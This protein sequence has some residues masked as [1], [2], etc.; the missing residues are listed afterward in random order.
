MPVELRIC[1]IGFGS[2][3]RTHLAALSALPV[4][5]PLPFRPVVDTVVTR[6]ARE[7][8][9]GLALAG[10]GHIAPAFGDGLAGRHLDAAVVASSNDRHLADSRA[11]LGAGLPLYVEK[12]IGRTPEEAAELSRLAAASNRPVQ[13]GLVMRY[14]PAVARSRALLAAG[15]AGAVRQARLTIF[16]GSYLDPSRPL[17]WRMSRERAGGGAM[18][19]L[20]LHLLDLARHLL[21]EMRLVAGRHHTFVAE[22][23]GG[24]ADADDWAWAELTTFAGAS[25]TVEASR[26]AYGGEGSRLEVFGTEGSLRCDLDEAAPPRLRR[27][28]GREREWLERAEGEPGVAAV[29][30]L[31]PPARQSLGLFTDLHAAALHHFLMRVAG[32]DPL[33]GLAP[34]ADDSAVAENLAAQALNVE[35]L[36]LVHA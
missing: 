14:H 12:P 16:H 6:R 26:I 9:P 1:V 20:G 36:E 29:D 7:L 32:R 17:S 3:A 34:S 21:G 30:G 2:I 11:V 18:L 28:D 24:R 15:A 13:V 5:R 8:A 22:R 19:D 27:F 4:L 25:V 23:P 31:L 10:V 35:A 33:P